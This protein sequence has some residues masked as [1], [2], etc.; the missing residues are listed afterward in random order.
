MLWQ[1]I[2][3]ADFVFFWLGEQLDLCNRLVRKARRH[4]KARVAGAAA[5]VHQAALRQQDD[6]FRC[7]FAVFRENHMVNLWLNF[8]PLAFSE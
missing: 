8:F 3:F 6:A 4:H 5:Q 1:H 7:F 2:H